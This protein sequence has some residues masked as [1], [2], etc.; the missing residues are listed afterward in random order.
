MI[1]RRPA[2]RLLALTLSA[3]LSSALAGC[4]SPGPS[5]GWTEA[6][7][8]PAPGGFARVLGW[9]GMGETRM[10]ETAGDETRHGEARHSMTRSVAQPAL[11]IRMA[12]DTDPRDLVG[13]G[14]SQLAERMG[15]PAFVRRDGPAEIWQYVSEGCVF[16]VYLYPQQSVPQVSY[17]EGRSRSPAG[18]IDTGTCFRSVFQERASQERA[19]ARLS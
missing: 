2:S 1:H 18:T 19:G 7:A 8:G 16:D 15:P 14:V 3:A 9:V 12:A 10:G 6:A 17:V 4:S 5:A 11:S 13:L